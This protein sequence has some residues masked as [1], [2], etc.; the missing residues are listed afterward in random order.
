MNWTTPAD[1]RAQLQRLW[2]DQSLLADVVDDVE[3]AIGDVSYQQSQ[4]RSRDPL[5]SFPLTLRFRKPAPR[6]LATSYEQAKDWIKSLEAGSKAALGFG[7]DILWEETNHRV[8]GRNVSPAAVVVLSR[9]DALA[10][11]AKNEASAQF[12][13]PQPVHDLGEQLEGAKAFT[14]RWLNRMNAE[15]LRINAAEVVDAGEEVLNA[16]GGVAIRSMSRYCSGK[17]AFRKPSR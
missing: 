3:S 5:I 1:I 14:C 7:Y 17:P 8:V 9:S 4:P 11:I 12:I 15:F 13:A 6:E 10:L 16:I 2:D